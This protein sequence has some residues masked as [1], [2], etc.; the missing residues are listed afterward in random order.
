MFLEKDPNTL[1]ATLVLISTNNELYSPH[2]LSQIH[3]QVKPSLWTQSFAYRKLP[4][5]G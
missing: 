2:N 4:F 1:A 5:C 3:N